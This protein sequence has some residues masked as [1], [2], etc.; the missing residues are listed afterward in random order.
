MSTPNTISNISSS[1]LVASASTQTSDLNQQTPIPELVDQS[2]QLR[3]RPLFTPGVPDALSL[4]NELLDQ[5]VTTAT[6]AA[7]AKAKEL[8]VISNAIAEITRRWGLIMSDNV[9]YTNPN[10]PDV[11]TPLG[12]GPSAE[13]IDEIHRIIR[14]DLGL[15][16][17][18]YEITGDWLDASKAMH[19]NYSK[20]QSLNAVSVAFTDKIQ[21]KVDT[22][23]QE[24]KNEMT[25]ITSAQDEIRNL[26]Q[27]IVQLSQS[28]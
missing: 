12:D 27:F 20:L 18:I 9:E 28:S 14:E 24:F 1:Q 19:V 15:N 8:E 6:G 11:T 4:V 5:F 2:K 16:N 23:Q 3:S 21:V 22:K 25:D 10:D 7:E 17:G 26:S 13:H